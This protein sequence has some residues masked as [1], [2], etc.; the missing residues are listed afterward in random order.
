MNRRLG[1]ACLM[2]A[3]LALVPQPFVAPH[4]P[5]RADLALSNAGPSALHPLGTDHLGRDVWARLVAGA[6]RSLATA[7]LAALVATAIGGALGATAGIAA[8]GIDVAVNGFTDLM[9]AFPRLVLLVTVA[10]VV[11]FRSSAGLGLLIG[12]T[13]WMATARLVRTETLGLRSSPFIE[14]ARAAGSGTARLLARHVA[15]Q[16]ARLLG[17][18]AGLRVASAIL[19]AASL[20]FL[21]LGGSA[22]APSWGRMVQEGY[23]HIGSA[24]WAVAAPVAVL[25]LVAV[26]LVL[27]ADGDGRGSREQTPAS[28]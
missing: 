2:L 13:S 3:L 7:L 12:L 21:G 18:S 14:A 22:D 26:G 25:C 15:P 19:S 9:L 1:F 8:G 10:A 17:Q 23:V 11:P 5:L 16:V 4:D 6:S 28:H 24:P 27:G 20:D